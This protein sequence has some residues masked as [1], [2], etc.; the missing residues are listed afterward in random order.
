MKKQKLIILISGFATFIFVFVF[1]QF[2]IKSELDGPQATT[3]TALNK[4][5]KNINNHSSDV[6]LGINQSHESKGIKDRILTKTKSGQMV[7]DQTLK[8]SLS[9]DGSEDDSEKFEIVNEIILIDGA[10]NLVLK[11]YR[12][13]LNFTFDNI[14]ADMYTV[15]I[16]RLK[17]DSNG[18]ITFKTEKA[19]ILNMVIISDTYAVLAQKVLV[20]Y[21]KNEYKAKLYK[22]GILEIHATNE[23]N[24]IVKDLMVDPQDWIYDEI[25]SSFKPLSFDAQRGLYT[26]INLLGTTKLTFHAKGYN[27]TKVYQINIAPNQKSY[28]EIRLQRPRKIFLSL[29]LDNKPEKIKVSECINKNFFF[30]GEV[31]KENEK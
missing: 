31:V 13:A 25:V 29:D 18:K 20:G 5:S 28:L 6:D 8:R 27:S 2:G 21:G 22:G 17:S 14:L 19:G 16:N 9:N 12:V 11:N 23:D 26:L 7:V 15:E 10:T 3:P 1:L 4:K 24:E 30:V